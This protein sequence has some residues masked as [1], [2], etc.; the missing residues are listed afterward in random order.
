M[1]HNRVQ[2]IPIQ[3]KRGF[4]RKVLNYSAPSTPHFHTVRPAT[5]TFRM[6]TGLYSYRSRRAFVGIHTAMESVSEPVC[7][8]ANYIMAALR[9]PVKL[10]YRMV[11][12]EAQFTRF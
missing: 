10:R 5:S 1:K 12:N 7:E 2:R 6:T 4:E 9:M 3:L 11:R 8:S